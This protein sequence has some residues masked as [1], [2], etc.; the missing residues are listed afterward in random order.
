MA[1]ASFGR[2]L[3]YILLFGVSLA[4]RGYLALALHFDGLYGQDAY[5]YYTYGQ[6][7][8]TAAAQFQP[9]PHFY[10][11]LGYPVLVAL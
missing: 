4:L 8:R 2:P 7:L 3:R 10:W 11:P 1:R 5:A 6:Q 9:S